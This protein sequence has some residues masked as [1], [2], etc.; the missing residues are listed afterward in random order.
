MILPVRALVL[1]LAVLVLLAVG[2]HGSA[3]A[4]V[5]VP[6]P[7]PTIPLLAFSLPSQAI[8]SPAVP[9]A[10]WTF[11]GC[12]SPRTGAP[13]VDVYSDGN[14]QLWIC[15]ACGQTGNPSP[16]K[17]RKTTQAELNTGRWCS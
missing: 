5:E 16:G 1:T 12:W 6:L 17:C 8:T 14:G 7:A 11:S 4:S 9:V 3:V 15:K 10:N 2:L 13:C